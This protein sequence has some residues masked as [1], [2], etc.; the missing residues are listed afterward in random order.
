MDKSYLENTNPQSYIECSIII[1]NLNSPIIDKTIQSLL[2]QVDSPSFEI[3]VV[4]MDKF[5]KIKDFKDFVTFLETEL[6]TPPGIARNLGIAKARGNLV[7]FIDADCIAESDWILQHMKVHVS[8]STPVAVSGSVTFPHK[9][10]LTLADNVSS[11]HEF[12]THMPPGERNYLP[13]LNL[14]IPRTIFDDFGGFNNNP[15]GEDTEFTAK[16]KK[17]KTK[18]IFTPNA[19]ITHLPSRNSIQALLQHAFCSGKYSIKGK[20]NYRDVLSIPFLLHHWLLVII[21]SPILAAGVIYKM[22]FR[23]FLPIMYW[24]TLPLVYLLKI[25]WCFG[26]SSQLRETSK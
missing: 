22:V 12:M 11:F 8:Y 20:L 6:P 13:S 2:D 1:P 24:H 23:E 5:E 19:K 25:A 3:I 18:L 16:I 17:K 10:F 15:S 7:L 26:F 9:K 4:G 14:S 21:F